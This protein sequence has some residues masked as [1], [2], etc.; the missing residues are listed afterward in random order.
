MANVTKLLRNLQEQGYVPIDPQGTSNEYLLYVIN[1]QPVQ[2]VVGIDSS[3]LM[4]SQVSQLY[5]PAVVFNGDTSLDAN[6]SSGLDTSVISNTA[7]LQRVLYVDYPEADPTIFDTVPKFIYK[8]G[9]WFEDSTKAHLHL[10]KRG[11][12]NTVAVRVFFPRI[13]S[14][15]SVTLVINY[16]VDMYGVDNAWSRQQG[17]YTGQYVPTSDDIARGFISIDVP[18]DVNQQNFESVNIP[19]GYP[20]SGH[21]VTTGNV[22]VALSNSNGTIISPPYQNSFTQYTGRYFNK[23]VSANP[24]EIASVAHKNGGSRIELTMYSGATEYVTVASTGYVGTLLSA[25]PET[26]NGVVKGKRYIEFSNIL[27]GTADTFVGLLYPVYDKNNVLRYEK[28]I[29]MGQQKASILG[30]VTDDLNCSV[31]QGSSPRFA[32]DFD[33]GALYMGVDG[34]WR[35]NGNWITSD[36]LTGVQPDGYLPFKPEYCGYP[37]LTFGVVSKDSINFSVNRKEKLSPTHVGYD[38]LHKP[39]GYEI[40]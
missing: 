27:Y 35:N 5:N 38:V 40:F 10:Y 32:V 20:L 12:A 36:D 2:K 17:S 4:A 22:A 13:L 16:T 39:T 11:G 23:V 21:C 30:Q 8:D 19:T 18:L 6:L 26:A 9:V 1:D 34:M 3:T 31:A 14:G 24:S 7:E 37:A 28:I 29:G 15:V 25:N 33:T